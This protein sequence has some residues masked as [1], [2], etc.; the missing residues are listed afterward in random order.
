MTEAQIREKTV[1]LYNAY[2]ELTGA[3]ILLGVGEFLA[4]RKAA[5]EEM[6]TIGSGK[7]HIQT[8]QTTSK[9]SQAA[10][11]P[12]ETQAQA[13]VFQMKKEKTEDASEPLIQIKRAE[14]VEKPKKADKPMSDFDVLRAAGDPWN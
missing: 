12:P 10:V 5:V 1:L 2:E 11:Q 7:G 4:M 8:H 13:N 3:D 6:R 9:P 14:R